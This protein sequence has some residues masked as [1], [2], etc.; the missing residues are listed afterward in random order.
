MEL[1]KA[2]CGA[3]LGIAA[4]M[5]VGCGSVREI[6]TVEP[7]GP[8]EA[9]TRP[10]H[11]FAIYNDDNLLVTDVLSQVRELVE[12]NRGRPYTD[13]YVVSH[14]WN[15]TISGAHANY[16]AYLEAVTR[17]LEEDAPGPDLNPLLI[18]VCWTSVTRPAGEAARSM[19]PFGLD[20]SIALATGAVDTVVFHLPSMWKQSINAATNALGRRLPDRYLVDPPDPNVAIS[21]SMGGNA[22]GYDL[23]V[24]ALLFYLME[25]N[26]D[27]L[28]GGGDPVRLHCAGHSFGSKLLLL[29]AIES[30]RRDRYLHPEDRQG[31]ESLTLFNAA[32]HP[33]EVSYRTADLGETTLLELDAVGLLKEIPRKAF[34][35]SRSDLTMG[36]TFDFSQIVINNMHAQRTQQVANDFIE[37]SRG[38]P[39]A[40]FMPVVYVGLGAVQFGWSTLVGVSMWVVRRAVNLPQD[41]V[42]HVN[43]SEFLGS[44]Q[45]AIGDAGRFLHFFLPLDEIYAGH[46]DQQGLFRASTG[47]LGKS[48]LARHAAGRDCEIDWGGSDLYSNTGALR[49]FVVPGSDVPPSEYRRLAA[50]RVAP[51]DCR[52]RDDG[53][54]FSF[55]ASD[56]LSSRTPFVGSHGMLREPR[57]VL[58]E[59]PGG[60]VRTRIIDSTVRF[61]LNFSHG[62]STTP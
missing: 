3:I 57:S 31:I 8:F 26:R 43:D 7:P 36:L 10:D 47:G 33:S 46:A 53:R 19:L 40:L 59:T 45:D 24:S 51:S 29:A 55:D 11:V 52:Y 56:V 1:E 27:G 38:G 22:R 15:F 16:E 21:R 41:L 25:W 58:L 35:Y 39:A 17:V 14:G 62:E 9:R 37:R 30:L 44:R 20:E 32:M 28:L 12:R 61:V 54:F 4:A 6:S 23:P 48:G 50:K 2:C 49:P 5:A 34:V 42:H 60:E 18:L 13:V